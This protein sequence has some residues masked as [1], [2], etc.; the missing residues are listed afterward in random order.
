MKVMDWSNAVF[1]GLLNVIINTYQLSQ[2]AW[3]TLSTQ[4]AN[5]RPSFF[6][7]GN[8]CYITLM[9]KRLG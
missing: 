6:V 8:A 5:R 4:R 7:N 2:K 3:F 1:H 9:Q